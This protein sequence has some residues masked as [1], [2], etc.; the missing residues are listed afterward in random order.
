[1]RLIYIIAPAE[2]PPGPAPVSRRFHS[3]KNIVNLSKYPVNL[4]EFI[5]I[6]GN[7]VFSN[8]PG[9][10]PIIREFSLSP[11]TPIAGK[12]AQIVIAEG[13]PIPIPDGSDP[14]ERAGSPIPRT[15]RV[16]PVCKLPGGKYHIHR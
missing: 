10:F 3:R 11:M 14:G 13:K 7:S 1:M 4:S 5:Y 16:A 2:K 9:G 8:A 6:F 12:C 15:T